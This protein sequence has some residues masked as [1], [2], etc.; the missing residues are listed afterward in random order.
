MKLRIAAA[1]RQASI[2]MGEFTGSGEYVT[3]G[4][5]PS[6][7]PN[8]SRKVTVLPL[9]FLIFYEVSGGP[10]G[11]EDTVH[12]AGPLLA[13][14]GF[15]LFP[16]IWSV[17]EALITAEMGTMFPENSGYVVWV[18]SALGP[19]W[20]FQQGWMK[21]LSGVI[22]NALYPV[23]FLDYLKSGIPALGGGLPRV[24]ATW[25]LTIVLTYLNYRGMTI[26]GWVAVCLGVFS[27]LPFVVMGFL[28]IPDLKPSRWTV[29]NLNDVNWNLYLNTL[30]WNLNYWDSISTLAG[31]VENP[32]K[33]LPKALFYAVILVVLGYF[34]PLL[35]GTGAVPV[36]REL[37]TDGYFSDIALIIGGAWLRWWLQA[38]AAMSNMG[39]FVAE[40]SSDAFQLLGMAER[41]M[42]PEFFGKRSR[43]GTPLI[44][45]LFSASGVILLSWLSFQ[46]IVA[47]EN[48]LYCFGMILEFIA[49]ILLRIKHP[50]ASRPYKIPGGTAGAIIMCIP[51]TILIG[52]VLFFSSLKVMV[53]SLIAM[54]IGLV[55]QPCLKLVEK[56]RWMK[57]SYSSELPD[58]GNQEGN[59][60]L[61][62]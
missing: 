13:L 33:T 44:G 31:E 41:G 23:L 18:S 14:I 20:G 61:V 35:I 21:W 22:D 4:E 26:V 11:V 56:K 29:T 37:W 19:Y 53:I 39:M 40:M 7:R 1:N 60:S 24:I 62:H 9:V 48:F 16:L 3:H 28:S 47:A 36:N 52:V 49:F 30:F 55:M 8:H 45:I 32:K 46:E 51:P 10:F 57:F 42:L 25:G 43:Y 38:A 54:A 34:F 6:S 27:L 59:R 5:L 15:L 12:A 58:F 17:P 50:N 2:K